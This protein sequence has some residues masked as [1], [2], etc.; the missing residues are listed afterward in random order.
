[1]KHTWTAF[2]LRRSPHKKTVLRVALPGTEQI[3]I[4]KKEFF[5]QEQSLYASVRF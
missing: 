1:M 3:R 4:K 5:K 2:L